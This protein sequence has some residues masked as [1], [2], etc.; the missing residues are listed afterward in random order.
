M[1]NEKME[2]DGGGGDQ[3]DGG[4]IFVGNIFHKKNWDGWFG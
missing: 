4:G 2:E 3:G 1:R